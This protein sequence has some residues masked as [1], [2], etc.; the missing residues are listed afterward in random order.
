MKRAAERAF[1]KRVLEILN[2]FD[3]IGVSPGSPGGP[4]IDEYENAAGEAEAVF[5][6]RGRIEFSDISAIWLKWFDD[7]LMNQKDVV[8]KLRQKLN[9]LAP[10]N[11]VNVD[12]AQF[13]KCYA[14]VGVDPEGDVL[15]EL[16]APNC[17]MC[18]EPMD[19]VVG[20]WWCSNC[21][22]SYRPE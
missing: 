13:T 18:L 6:N 7:D 4:P 2:R 17:P 22:V 14:T 3:V 10:H 5:L 12:Q 21:Q 20:A 16:G 9:S 1:Y 8:A 15:D 19:P 11:P